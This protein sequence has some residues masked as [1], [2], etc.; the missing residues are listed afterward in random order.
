MIHGIYV[1]PDHIDFSNGDPYVI[2]D[3]KVVAATGTDFESANATF[4]AY[5]AGDPSSRVQNNNSGAP[6]TPVT[7]I[8]PSYA[9]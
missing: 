1:H 7:L 5:I 9:P 2:E 8:R 4:D 3:N 6:G